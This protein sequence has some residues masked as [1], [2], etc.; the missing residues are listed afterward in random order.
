MAGVFDFV[1][2]INKTKEDLWATTENPEKAYVP[3]IVN[4]ALSYHP[5]TVIAASILNERPQLSK[6]SQFRVL[7]ALV[8]PAQRWGSSWVKS[9]TDDDEITIA[10]FHAC[11]RREARL[12]KPYTTPEMIDAMRAQLERGGDK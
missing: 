12:L 4:R 11:S 10:A 6:R 8:P 3:F 2:A 1:N 5:D 9:E 7:L